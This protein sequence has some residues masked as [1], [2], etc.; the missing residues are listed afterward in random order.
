MKKIMLIIP[1][2][3]GGGAE[4]TIANLSYILEKEYKVYTVVFSLEEQMYKCGGEIISLDIGKGKNFFDR[5]FKNLLR[6]YKIYKLK[7]ELKIDISISFLDT[8]NLL[9][10]LTR[11]KDKTII[12]IRTI[13]SPRE[14]NYFTKLVSKFIFSK[15]DSI[16]TLSKEVEKDLLVN[17]YQKNEKIKTIYNICPIEL[18]R[19][20][21][22]EKL[23]ENIFKENNFNCITSGRLITLKGQWHLIRVLAEV[24]K[25]IPNIKLFILGKG[26]LEEKLKTLVKDYSL[27]E[28]VIFLGFKKNPYK[29]INKADLFL[30]SSLHEGLG[31]VLIETL[32]IGTPIISSNCIAGPREILLKDI[33]KDNK[34]KI[35]Y[36]DY[37]ILI[38]PFKNN[39]F[40][41]RTSLNQ[42]EENLKNL[43]IECYR[44]KNIYERY[45][46]T[47]KE[48]IKDFSEEKIG[49]EWIEVIEELLNK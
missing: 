12:S 31:N 21:S 19:N 26:E 28:N 9:N 18:I 4:K 5:I 41:S 34:E 27:E 8:P 14:K 10:V 16:I 1:T 11:K 43:L 36:G 29:Y 25:E 33:K 38:P 46:E 6:I 3:N 44:D 20:K 30:F 17:Y 15:S 48:R 47:S 39:N 42:Q 13:L 40:D 45:R 37:G 22:K 7:K 35:I 24:R 32:A 23:E 49:Q 2:L